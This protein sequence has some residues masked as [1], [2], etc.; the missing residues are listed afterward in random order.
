MSRRDISA[1]I[2]ARQR[3]TR[4]AVDLAGAPLFEPEEEPVHYLAVPV[5][6]DEELERQLAS[7]N[8][9]AEQAGRAGFTKSGLIRLALRALVEASPDEI[10]A[11]H[12]DR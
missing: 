3:S 10:V 5:A 7:I 6:L 12:A 9:T 4:E 11:R 2:R 8:R 1:G